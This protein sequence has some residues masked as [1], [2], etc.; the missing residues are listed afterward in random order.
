MEKHTGTTVPHILWLQVCS[1]AGVQGAITLSWLIYALYLPR[2]LSGFG[3]PETLAVW[4]LILE[5]ALAVVMEP[6]FG[7]LSDKAKHQIGQSFPF[8]SLGVILSSALFIAIPTLT[9]FFP[10]SDAIRIILPV[11]TIAWAMAMTVFRSP[12]IA[13]LGRYSRPEELPLAGSVL[14]LAGGIIG[15][16]RATAS[17]F[18]LSLGPMLTFAIG[19]FVLLASTA[20]LRFFNPV[21]TPIEKAQTPTRQGELSRKLT[22]ILFVGLGISWGSRLFIDAL[23]KLLKIQLNTQNIDGMM[24]VIN[25]ALAF[26][27]LPA[28]VLA[29]KLGNRKAMLVGIG[30]IVFLMISLLFIGAQMPLVLLGV[31]AFS[32]IL[33]GAIP[34]VLGLVPPKWGGLGVGMYFAGV[35]LTG[36]LFGLAFPQPQNITPVVGVVG[37][38]IAF[39]VAG[40]CIAGSYTQHLN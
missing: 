18:I 3:F 22:L 34:F 29:V 36:S 9:V 19:S 32:L 28:G 31:C 30:A 12:A 16:F 37:G 27:A 7:A 8:I 33:N 25:L 26:A 10:P 6:L 11:V 14:T 35:G 20:I 13:L 1:L 38:V 21:E 39:L 5:N 23:G 17:Q 24:F 15:A 4:V 2:L 40:V